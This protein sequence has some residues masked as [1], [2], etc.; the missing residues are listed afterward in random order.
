MDITILHR[1]CPDFEIIGYKRHPG[2]IDDGSKLL[3]NIYTISITPITKPQC[4]IVYTLNN[5]AVFT[6]LT[7]LSVASCGR[8][9]FSFSLASWQPVKFAE[10]SAL[11]LTNLVRALRGCIGATETP[12]LSRG[13]IPINIDEVKY[14]V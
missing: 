13:P 2:L 4:S 8:V 10:G 14:Y 6:E 7:V 12:V 3:Y 5:F 9:A 1:G 11:A